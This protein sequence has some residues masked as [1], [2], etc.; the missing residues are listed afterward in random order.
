MVQNYYLRNIFFS[1][2]TDRKKYLFTP[3]LSW[4]DIICSDAYSE[5]FVQI[6]KFFKCI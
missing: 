3:K 2:Y 5:Y 6:F 1:F 4:M